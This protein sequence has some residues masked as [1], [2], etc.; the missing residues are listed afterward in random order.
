MRKDKVILWMISDDKKTT[1]CS[2]KLSA[3]LRW[4][5]SNHDGEFYL[6]LFWLILNK[7][8]TSVTQKSMWKSRLVSYLK[9]LNNSIKY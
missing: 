1:F 2:K 3:L 8:Q 4:T 9:C 7:N 6:I 5:T